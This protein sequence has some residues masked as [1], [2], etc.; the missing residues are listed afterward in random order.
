MARVPLKCLLAKA[1]LVTMDSH[2]SSSSSNL[3][4]TTTASSCLNNNNSNVRES[5]VDLSYLVPGQ[6]QP[7]QGG[8]PNPYHYYDPS[9]KQ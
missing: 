8:Q 2:T 3:D 4:S 5:V 9:K 1:P 7:P 6:Q